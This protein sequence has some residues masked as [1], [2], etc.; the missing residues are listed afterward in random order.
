MNIKKIVYSIFIQ[1]LCF[2]LAFSSAFANVSQRSNAIGSEISYEELQEKLITFKESIEGKELSPSCSDKEAEVIDQAL[3]NKT[4]ASTEVSEEEFLKALNE[5]I[6]DYNVFSSEDKGFDKYLNGL[7]TNA[8]GQYIYSWDKE[9]PAEENKTCEPKRQN[10]YIDNVVASIMK[11]EADEKKPEPFRLDNPEVRKHHKQAEYLLQEVRKYLVHPDFSIEERRELLIS[12]LDSVALPMRDLIV[13]LR[14][15]IPQEYNGVFFY[16]SLLPD[17]SMSLF[18]EE[19][20]GALDRLLLGPN[21]SVKPFYLKLEVMKYGRARVRYREVEILGRD[22]TLLMKAPTA[23]NYTRA[24]KWM[25]LQMMLQQIFIYKSM[26]GDT[27]AES[28][29]RSCSNHFN[30]DLPSEIAFKYNGDQGKDFIDNILSKQGM[31]YDKDNYQFV[32]YYMNA[33][34][35]DPLKDG[36]SGMMPFEEYKAAMIGLKEEERKY[37]KPDFD[38][39]TYF[40]RIFEFKYPEAV[41]KFKGKTSSWLG[42]RDSKS[43]TYMGLDLLEKIMT[44]PGEYDVYEVELKDGEKVE[45]SPQRQNLSKFLA[46]VMQRNGVEFVEDL[47]TGSVKEKLEKTIVKVPFPSLYGSH[48]WKTWAMNEIGRWAEEAMENGVEENTK[49]FL[50]FHCASN[51]SVKFCKSRDPKE[52]VSSI[53]SFVE[54]I[55]GNGELVPTRRIEEEGLEKEYISLGKIWDYLRDRTNDLE[56]ARP[57]EYNFLVDQ[58]AAKNPWA[59]LRLSFLIADN[60]LN[61]FAKGNKPKYNSRGRVSSKYKNVHCTYRNVNS[62]KK[63]LAEAAE[64][65]KMDRPLNINHGNTIL[66]EDEMKA[67]WDMEI[68]S[69]DELLKT[70]KSSDDNSFYSFLDQTTYKTLLT[71]KSAVEASDDV[72]ISLSEENKKDIQKIFQS[73]E[74]KLGSFFLELYKLRGNVD[75]QLQYFEDFSAE[76]G[77]DNKFSVKAN[78]LSLDNSVKRVVLR[79]IVQESAKV[80]MGQIR[81]SLT[82]FCQLEPTDHEHLQALFFASSKAQNMLNQ[83]AG[84]PS[85]PDETLEKINDKINSMSPSEKVDMWLG[86]GAGLLGMAAIIIG[87]ACTGVTGGLCAPLGVAMMAAGASALTMQISLVGR[88]LD[89]KLQADRFE[90]QISVLEDLGFANQGSAYTVSRSWAWTIIEAVSIIPMIGVVSR[91]VAVGSKIAVVSTA[92]LARNTGK[93]GFKQAWRLAGQAGKTVV[94]EADVNMAKFVLGFD[95]LFKQTGR[96]MQA[97]AKTSKTM[98][99]EIAKLIG[100]GLDPK[101]VEAT[102]ERIQKLF[103]LF[104]RGRISAQALAQK[105][106]VLYD[107]LKTMLKTGSG[108]ASAYVSKVVVDMTPEVID[109]RTAKVVSRYFGNNPKAMKRLMGL[110]VK[111]LDKAAKVMGKIENGTSRIGKVPVLGKVVNWY[112]KL[113]LEHLAKYS[114]TIRGLDDGLEQLVKNGGD[115][116]EFILKNMDDLTDVFVKIPALRREFPY[117]VL[118]QGGPHIGGPNFGK[119]VGLI[120]WMSDGLIMRKFFN[121]R[122][123]LVYESLKGQ[124]RDMLKLGKYIGAETTLE[125]FKAFQVSVADAVEKLPEAEGKK[126]LKQ[127]TEMEIKIAERILKE[128]EGTVNQKGMVAKIR[129][130]FMKKRMN[131]SR[132]FVGFDVATVRKYLFN[133]DDDY[134]RALGEVI[135]THINVDNVFELADVGEVAHR[136]I[137]ELSNY[138]NVGEFE[139]YMNA[140]KVLVLKRDPG[141][142]EIM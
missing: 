52:I 67:M 21:P 49:L 23:M 100:K 43:Y 86:I 4:E 50:N 68:S 11:N 30:G 71:P 108:Q 80:R 51:T 139:K 6:D 88:E 26:I 39:M 92:T 33:Y 102:M 18:P 58:M 35:K 8:C 5:Q 20:K 75:K 99:D 48:L 107:G 118:F 28:I 14:S 83:L 22:I 54:E 90:K 140:L 119:R 135:W 70:K 121:A 95:G 84:A 60:E 59:R 78:F 79:N 7:K 87:A 34:N 96:Y 123:R 117:I 73:S 2:D 47:I 136:V 38:D 114:G 44:Q 85:I 65:F 125:S 40:Q 116:E 115:L 103:F 55:T 82:E 91:S 106:G 101:L 10:G 16:E 53:A 61:E 112:R 141:V 27:S 66:D 19:D 97:I 124:A 41:S 98:A 127:Y 81:N 57:T 72:G 109:G 120:S 142:V 134:Q 1:F 122:S 17:F 126:L 9:T 94:S 128:T 137:K 29:P 113:R 46:E 36:Y 77:I 131:A 42:M 69:K 3:K 105:V 64:V 37:I 31:I 56:V 138:N 132:E 133:P 111:K 45:I 89:R 129:D 110:Y 104:K 32:E 25:T 74:G 62:V 15:Y 76:N 130:T 12:Y 63:H 24:L 13:I 93:V